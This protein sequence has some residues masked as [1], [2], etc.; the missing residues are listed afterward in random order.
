M[1]TANGLLVGAA[2]ACLD[3][4]PLGSVVTVA[5]QGTFAWP[6][7]AGLLVTHLNGYPDVSRDG[8]S[9]L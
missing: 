4:L 8:K 6:D 5:G 3:H 2:H 7:R 1:Q 9:V